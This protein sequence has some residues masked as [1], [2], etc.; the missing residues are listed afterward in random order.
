MAT[1]GSYAQTLRSKNAGAFVLTMDVI[2]RSEAD[3]QRIVQSP[4]LTP[5]RIA[6]LYGVTPADVQV[7]PYP[8]V[9][10]VKVTLPRAIPSGDVGD[11]D[12]YG[13]QQHVPLMLLEVDEL[14]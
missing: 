11:S 9:H 6:A 10:A 7:I 5:E 4:L 13:A 2:F 3:Y 14:S 1:L 12:V 8:Q